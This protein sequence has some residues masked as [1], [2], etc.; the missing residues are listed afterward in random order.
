MILDRRHEHPDDIGHMDPTDE[1]PSVTHGAAQKPARQFLQHWKG[2]A[3]TAQHYSESEDHPA[4]GWKIERVE[5]AFPLPADF[6]GEIVTERGMFIGHAI[7]GVAVI[8]NPAGLHED[9]RRHRAICDRFAED[10]D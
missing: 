2:A 1:L 5:R 8:T 6:G 3:I 10:A 7:A 9:S 4:C